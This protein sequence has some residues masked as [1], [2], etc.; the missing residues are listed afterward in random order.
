MRK[1]EGHPVP[2]SSVSNLFTLFQFCS[3]NSKHHFTALGPNSVNMYHQ[4]GILVEAGLERVKGCGEEQMRSDS[5][6]IHEQ[7]CVRKGKV[8]W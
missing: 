6:R 4:I 5:R 8:A 2:Y 7:Q 3:V 1:V